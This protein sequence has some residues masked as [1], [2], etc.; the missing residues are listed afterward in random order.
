MMIEKKKG[1]KGGFRV[2]VQQQTA[3]KKQ[4][5]CTTAQPIEPPSTLGSLWMHMQTNTHVHEYVPL[6]LSLSLSFSL[7]LSLSDSLSLLLYCI[8][9]EGAM[10]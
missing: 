3:N 8:S 9:A 7:S 6:S 10:N 5:P 4:R 2:D 1:K